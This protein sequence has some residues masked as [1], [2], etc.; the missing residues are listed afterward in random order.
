[1]PVESK[2]HYLQSIDEKRV[3]LGWAEKHVRS[4]ALAYRQAQAFEPTA[5]WLFAAFAE[6]SNEPLLTNINERLL[7]TIMDRLGIGTLLRRCTAVLG[8]EDMRKMEASERLIALCHAVGAQRYLSGPA[9]KA[10]LDQERF[11]RAGITIEWINY[12]GYPQY[13]QLWG[14]FVPNVS[15]VDLLFN[16]GDEAIKYLRPV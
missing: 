7:R 3:T 1:M 4:V 2:G 14:A 16:T 6:V 11:A 5:A 12:D 10:Y 9:A 15:I 8:R 13:P